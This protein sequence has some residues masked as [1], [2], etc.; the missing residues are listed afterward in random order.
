MNE[1]ILRRVLETDMVGSGLSAALVIAAAQ[2]LSDTLDVPA[3]ALVGL[4]IVLIP[5]VG[6]LFSSVRRPRLRRGD[7]AVVVAGNLLWALAAAIMIWGFPASL[8]AAGKWIVGCFSLA[9]LA[10]GIV[11][12][13][14][15]GA[16][17]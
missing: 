3:A 12:L 5:W 11:E 8:S 17:D 13:R 9:V 7:V 16:L 4:G 6:F 10:L 14:G 1:A 2:P 15:L